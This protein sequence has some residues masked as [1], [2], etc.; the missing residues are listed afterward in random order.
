[1]IAY[2]VSASGGVGFDLAARNASCLV[3][4][5]QCGGEDNSW[6]MVACLRVCRMCLVELTTVLVNIVRLRCRY[7]LCFS[8]AVHLVFVAPP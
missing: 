8:F 2:I 5:R 4:H 1:M 6:D 7:A 3:C